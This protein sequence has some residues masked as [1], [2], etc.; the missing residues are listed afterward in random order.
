MYLTKQELEEHEQIRIDYLIENGE[1]VQYGERWTEKTTHEWWLDESGKR[2]CRLVMTYHGGGNRG[3]DDEAE[4][5]RRLLDTGR[6]I[7]ANDIQV[8]TV[9]SSVLEQLRE[10]IPEGPITHVIDSRG[11]AHRFR[12]YVPPPENLGGQ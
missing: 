1:A 12:Y 5:V 10:T 6:A 4:Y 3:D 11:K 8:K 2:H 7:T 9:D